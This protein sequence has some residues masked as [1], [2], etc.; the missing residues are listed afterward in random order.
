[1]PTLA[2]LSLQEACFPSDEVLNPPPP[3][4]L[5][6]DYDSDVSVCS[7]VLS[8]AGS[9]AG[10]FEEDKPEVDVQHTA[11]VFLQSIQK[12]LKASVKDLAV[13]AVYEARNHVLF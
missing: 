6:D 10:S 7:T 4:N 13:S 2:N 5:D 11:L 3:A 8:D 1:M 9:D 12:A